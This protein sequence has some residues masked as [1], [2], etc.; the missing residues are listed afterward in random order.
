VSRR[1]DSAGGPR[2]LRVAALLAVILWSIATWELGS[3]VMDKRV[4]AGLRA[5]LD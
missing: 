1:C 4:L 3:A 5:A 2:A